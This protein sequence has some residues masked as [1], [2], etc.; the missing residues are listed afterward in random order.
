[1]GVVRGGEEVAFM[2]EEGEVPLEEGG[3]EEWF[4]ALG[5]ECPC[6]VDALVEPAIDDDD[7]FVVVSFGVWLAACY[8][9]VYTNG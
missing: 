4:S 7:D 5:V 2:G 8:E 6:G 1:M 9:R 3:F